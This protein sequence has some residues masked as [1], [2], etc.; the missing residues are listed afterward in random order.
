M[1]R[2]RT[3]IKSIRANYLDCSCGQPKEGSVGE[4]S[5]GENMPVQRVFPLRL[6]TRRLHAETPTKKGSFAT[7]E[8]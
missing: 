1:N 3:P 6:L 4:A 2:T 7:E 8:C 5:Q